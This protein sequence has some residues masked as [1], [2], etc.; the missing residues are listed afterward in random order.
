MELAFQA[1]D[2]RQPE[3]SEIG[4]EHFSGSDGSRLNPLVPLVH[5]VS[6]EEIGLD[7]PKAGL[8]ILMTELRFGRVLYLAFFPR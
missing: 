3:P 5:F 7:F 4:N 6:F 1:I 2:L 8:G